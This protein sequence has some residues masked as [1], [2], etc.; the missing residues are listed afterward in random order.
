[1]RMGRQSDTAACSTG[2]G[3]KVTNGVLFRPVLTDT[4]TTRAFPLSDAP[5]LTLTPRRWFAPADG[6]TK[7]YFDITLRDANGA[8]AAGPR[9]QV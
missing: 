5:I 7:V 4:L 1:M 9:R 6:T 8:P 3:D 2:Q